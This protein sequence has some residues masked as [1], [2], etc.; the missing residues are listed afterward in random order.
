ME[1]YDDLVEITPEIYCL[2]GNWMETP[3]RRRMTIL[4]LKNGGLVIHSAIQLKDDDY[5]KIDALG[6]VEYIVVP[7]S[8]HNSD[9]RFFAARY[10]NAKVFVPKG[11]AESVRKNCPVHGILPEAWT[12]KLREEIGC[13]EFDGT[14]GLSENVFFHRGSKTLLVTDLVF[15]MQNE[16]SGALKVFFKLNRIYKRFGP[17]RI[18]RYGFVNQPKVAAESFHEMMHWDFDRVI[19]NHGEILNT[20]GKEAL[21]KGFEEMGLG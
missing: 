12:P 7:N 1:G 15:N 20:G 16:V 13:Q 5:S 17:S 18:F 3:F 4:R 9:A 2:D 11:A 14:R 21:R 8:Y 10:P 6:R 19:M